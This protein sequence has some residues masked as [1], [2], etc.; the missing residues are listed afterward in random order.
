M[1]LVFRMLPCNTRASVFSRAGTKWGL[2]LIHSPCSL[3]MCLRRWFQRAC[4]C[5]FNG[6]ASVFPM[7]L[8]LWFQ[9]A[10]DAKSFSVGDRVFV[11]K[12]EAK[13]TVLWKGDL[14]SIYACPA[15]V[16]VV[17]AYTFNPCVSLCV[18]V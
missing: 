1:Q 16:V 7:Y 13:G 12:Y 3:A 2:D 11:I 10:E 8:R 6:P 4:V 15:V 18:Q 17:H 14:C 5:G 9:C